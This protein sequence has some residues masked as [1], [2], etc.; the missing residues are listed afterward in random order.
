MHGAQPQRTWREDGS[1]SPGTAWRGDRLPPWGQDPTPHLDWDP[2]LHLDPTPH[3]DSAPHLD[4][5]RALFLRRVG[6]TRR[7]ACHAVA[8]S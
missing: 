4:G 8:G 7:G 1:Y 2:T 3:L 6:S 5:T